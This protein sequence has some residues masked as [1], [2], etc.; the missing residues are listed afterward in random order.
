M[1]EIQNSKQYDLEDRIRAFAKN[2]RSFVKKVKKTLSNIE[3]C[4]R[5]NDRK[6][7]EHL[8]FGFRICFGFRIWDLE[9]YDK[10][11]PLIS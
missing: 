7:F 1:T 6:P 5:V 9:F 10:T 8:N 3:D 4:K 2:V 11:D